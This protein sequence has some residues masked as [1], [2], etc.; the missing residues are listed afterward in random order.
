MRTEEV[1]P[2]PPQTANCSA[3]TVA[4]RMGFLLS[5]SPRR[6]GPAMSFRVLFAGSLQYIGV[7]SLS[8]LEEGSE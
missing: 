2:A 7:H 6:R 1:A 8:V 3:A 4:S 5:A